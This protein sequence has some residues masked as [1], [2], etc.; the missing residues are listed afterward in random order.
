ML[1]MRI[2][3]ALR[4]RNSFVNSSADPLA[5][6]RVSSRKIVVVIDALDEC[7]DSDVRAREDWREFLNTIV[8]WSKDLPPSC[9]LVVTSRIEVGIE[10][11]L[12]NISHPLILDTGDRVSAESEGDIRLYFE[13]KFRDME[14]EDAWPGSEAIALLTKYAAG[15]FIWARMVLGFVGDGIDPVERLREVLVDLTQVPDGGQ[16]DRL[17]GRVLFKIASRLRLPVERDS[18]SLVLASLVLMK[19]RGRRPPAKKELLEL[20]APVGRSSRP[21]NNAINSLATV[22]AADADGLEL[23]A[24]HKSFSDF[25]QNDDRVNAL[26]A[27][28]LPADTPDR[29]SIL[30]IFSR[31][32]QSALLAEVC[33]QLMNQRLKFNIFGVPSSHYRTQASILAASLEYACLNFAGHLQDVLYGQAQ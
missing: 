26:M 13:T 27:N 31:A 25:V 4:S 21:I 9:K 1:V 3:K 22:I 17:Y 12:R 20:L 16:L 18:L 28:L 29:E 8:T 23:R 10:K 33:L 11:K 5:V 6:D 30:A 2:L 7:D 14:V 15:L 32:R 24:F 19:T